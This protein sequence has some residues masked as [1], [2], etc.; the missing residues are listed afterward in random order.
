MS[1]AFRG[2]MQDP[3]VWPVDERLRVLTELNV[4]AQLNSLRAHPAVAR[5]LRRGSLRIH[6][7]VYDIGS[8]EI[9]CLDPSTGSFR[10]LLLDPS[11][12]ET[13]REEVLVA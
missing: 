10:S 8:G 5:S 12:M 7:W 4:V 13:A 3:R 2:V 11:E 9:H 1:R 6:G